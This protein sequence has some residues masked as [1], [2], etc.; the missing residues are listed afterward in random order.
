MNYFR[1]LKE[2]QEERK[3]KKKQRLKAQEERKLKKEKRLKAQKER[4]LKKKK[5]LKEK[6]KVGKNIAKIFSF[7]AQLI[8]GFIIAVFL[9]LIIIYAIF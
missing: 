4:K 9:F 2:Q 8:I 3:L 6:N 7:V 5:R 1:F